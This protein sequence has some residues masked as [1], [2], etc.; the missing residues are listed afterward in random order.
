[1]QLKRKERINEKFSLNLRESLPHSFTKLDFNEFV[2][3]SNANPYFAKSRRFFDQYMHE[4][5]PFDLPER[6]ILLR[7]KS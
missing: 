1:M 4:Y 2:S 7:D 3:I 6:H 5:V